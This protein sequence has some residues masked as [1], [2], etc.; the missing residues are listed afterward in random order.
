MGSKSISRVS[1]QLNGRAF[2]SP[3]KGTKLKRS[4]AYH[5]Q[6]DDQSEVVNMCLETYLHCFVSYSP[7]KWAKWLSWAEFCQQTLVGTI[8]EYLEARDV[9][10]WDLKGYLLRAQQLM[11]TKADLHHKDEEFSVGDKV[12]LKLHLYRQHLVAR[13]VNEKLPSHYFGPFKVLE[14]IGKVVYCLKL[15][16]TSKIHDVFHISQLKKAIGNQL[17]LP[18]LPAT[19]TTDME[20]LL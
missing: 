8:K 13:R 15:S 16:E 4:N 1:W 14:R 2:E 6:T 12:F 5:P 10:L 11:K 3:K 9:V 18:S 17:A 7:K 20:V 19:L